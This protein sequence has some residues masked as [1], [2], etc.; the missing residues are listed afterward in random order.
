MHG[1]AST[2]VDYL[3]LELSTLLSLRRIHRVYSAVCRTD[4]ESTLL[5][6]GRRQL[7]L[8]YV[9]VGRI[10]CQIC[11]LH[12]GYKVYSA[13]CRTNTESTILCIC[14]KDTESILCFLQE[15]YKVYSAACR[16]NTESTLLSAGWIHSLFSCLL[17]GYRVYSAVY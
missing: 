14:R 8:S 10:Q 7:L 16:T 15:G 3:G 13:V 17:D 11:S 9:S 1:K 12:E 5:S 6:A 2:T 4:T